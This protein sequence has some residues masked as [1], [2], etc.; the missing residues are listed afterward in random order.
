MKPNIPAAAVVN[1]HPVSFL[2]EIV[3]SEQPM[4]RELAETIR[5]LRR[6]HLLAYEDIMFALAESEPDRGQ[7]HG[8]GKAL[9]ELAACELKD[10]DPTW[11]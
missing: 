3:Y 9:T 8:F 6:E 7:C 4:P 1:R 2:S 11:T 10:N 5:T